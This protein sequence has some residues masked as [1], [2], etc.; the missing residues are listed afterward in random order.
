MRKGTRLHRLLAIGVAMVILLAACGDDD[1]DVAEPNGPRSN[2]AAAS[3]DV[4]PN[5]T[6]VM[7]F[8]AGATS[9]DPHLGRAGD[10]TFWGLVFDRLTEISNEDLSVEPMLATEWS[11]SEDGSTFDMS[12]REDVIFQ[13]GTPFNADA[14]VA[15]IDRAKTIEG[16]TVA[17]SLAPVDRVEAVDEYTARFHLGGPIANLPAVLASPAG[18]M[19]SPA[20]IEAGA[21]LS[22]DPGDA[23]SGGYVVAAHTPL[24]T[25]TFRR[26]PNVWNPLSG[27]LAELRIDYAP[28]SE[29]RLNGLQSGEFDL[30]A[31]T[32][33]DAVFGLELMEEDE[34][35]GE[36]VMIN[37]IHGVMLNPTRGVLADQRVRQAINYAIDREAIAEGLFDGNC[38]QRFQ[39]FPE[40]TAWHLPGVDDQY[41]YDPDRARELIAETGLSDV[42]FELRAPVGP[43]Y[44]PLAQV[45]Q[46]QLAEVGITANVTTG[47]LS[48]SAVDFPTGKLDA[49]SLVVLGQ[50]DPGIV[51]AQWYLGGGGA[52]MLPP[53]FEAT[54]SIR[55]QAA[56][57]LENGLTHEERLDRYTDI[58]T[59][60]GDQSVWVPGC[61]TMQVWVH[62]PDVVGA[63][64]MPFIW[65][66]TVVPYT[67]GKTR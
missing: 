16:S 35:E 55:Q 19:I 66:G 29:A 48:T 59:E 21:D 50:S 32:G 44:Q 33:T 10:M 42:T 57:A 30:I 17:N 60:L 26:A 15:S 14:V 46:A 20:A 56:A 18:A 5:G 54:S 1:E 2:E 36:P 45:M 49:L 24:E 8:T 12:L 39:V 9:L 37:T 63:A 3:G 58:F 28:A 31:A 7:G 40:G 13:D 51:L 47:E 34:F 25:T 53:D 11:F 43:S 27:R 67:L 22:T 62:G 52:G 38:E 61:A 6:L 41:P 64:E 4:D 65:Q 23:G